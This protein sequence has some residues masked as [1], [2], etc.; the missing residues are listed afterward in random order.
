[1]VLMFKF[2]DGILCICDSLN[3]GPCGVRRDLYLSSVVGPAADWNP[4]DAICVRILKLE[5]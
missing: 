5:E 2:Q 1:M 3:S 4:F